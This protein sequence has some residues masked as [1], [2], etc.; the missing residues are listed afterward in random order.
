MGVDETRSDHHAAGVDRLVDRLAPA[1]LGTDMENVGAFDDYD[2]IPQVAM[3]AFLKR[4]HVRG[5]DPPPSHR[6]PLLFCRRPI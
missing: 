4:D 1:S 6:S 2:P 3:P 5:V